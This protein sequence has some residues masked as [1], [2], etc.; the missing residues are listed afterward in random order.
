M[1]YNGLAVVSAFYKVATVVTHFGP[2]IKRTPSII[3]V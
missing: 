3:I 1:I 2:V